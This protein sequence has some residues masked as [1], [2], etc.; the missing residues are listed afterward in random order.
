LRASGA[1]RAG[2]K[3]NF[4]TLELDLRN[5]AL[6]SSLLQLVQGIVE[7]VVS[8]QRAPFGVQRD[9]PLKE[10]F[11]PGL[12]FSLPGVSRS[13]LSRCGGDRRSRSSRPALEAAVGK[14]RCNGSGAEQDNQNDELHSYIYF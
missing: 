10:L 11:A 13:T 9:A 12:D 14:E 1:L 7:S 5:L 6:L 4:F 8:A 2:E 3:S